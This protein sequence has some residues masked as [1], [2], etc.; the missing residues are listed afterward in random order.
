MA[1]IL[2]QPPQFPVPWVSVELDLSN[3][4]KR[5]V[6]ER[7]GVKGEVHRQG[8]FHGRFSIT[9]APEGYTLAAA[10]GVGV[11]GY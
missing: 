10:K 11:P 5:E 7:L 1:P 6:P 4:G 9:M 8:D 2:A 3:L